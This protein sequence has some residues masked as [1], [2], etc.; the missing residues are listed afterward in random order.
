MDEKAKKEIMNEYSDSDFIIEPLELSDTSGDD[1]VINSPKDNISYKK[2]D[3][4]IQCPE[5]IPISFND[6]N[7]NNTNDVIIQHSESIPINFN[8]NNKL[9]RS[10]G[11]KNTNNK[12]FMNTKLSKTPEHKNTYL[13]GY[14]NNCNNNLSKVK[15]AGIIPYTFKD[16]K[17]LFLFQQY[18]Y[19]KEG[20]YTDFGGKKE[21]YESEAIEIATREFCEET[22]CLFYFREVNN[23]EKYN[24]Y[25][26]KS[27]IKTVDSMESYIHHLD[28]AKQYYY[29]LL[30]T[31]LSKNP[32]LKTYIKN[33]YII[34]FLYVPH[35]DTS[36]LS[37][38][39]DINQNYEVNFERKCEWL[40]Y[41]EIIK[42]ENNDFHKRLQ[43][44]NIINRIQ[45]LYE[46]DIF[47]KF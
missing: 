44:L 37:K 26:Q 7:E 46:K 25:K 38:Y 12:I 4:N 3:D 5:Y 41:D 2:N 20:K 17:L 16:N 19:P 36:D 14:K 21:D 42:L 31:R 28:L 23:F 27:L 8:S 45:I 1:T 33:T 13:N 43:I 29:D 18:I 40:S 32:F 22:A 11:Y 15:G 9:S 24:Y 6:D 47:Y 10:Y 39:E 35:I 30:K 34:F